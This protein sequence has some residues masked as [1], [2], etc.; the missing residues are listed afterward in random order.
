PAASFTMRLRYCNGDIC[1]SIWIGVEE[2][3]S[4]ST[5]PLPGGCGL[6]PSSAC[7]TRSRHARGEPPNR[8]GT[9]LSVVGCSAM[10]VLPLKGA[11]GPCT[12]SSPEH[13]VRLTVILDELSQCQALFRE[14][15][16]LRLQ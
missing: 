12:L 10:N 9:S 15:P 6:R 3:F 8:A 5:S 13:I 1:S 14:Y 11:S 7:L 4:S 2:V 16:V